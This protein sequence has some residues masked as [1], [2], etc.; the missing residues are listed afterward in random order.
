MSTQRDATPSHLK[1][2]GSLAM[3]DTTAK[4]VSERS[5]HA[6]AIVRMLPETEARL[7]AATLP[8]GD[9]FVAAQLAGIMAAKQTASLVP[10]AHPISISAVDVSLSWR[11]PG[12]LSIDAVAKTTASTGVEMEAMV[13][14]TIAA[15]TI[16]D[17]TKSLERGVRIESVRLLHKQG[18]RSGEWRASE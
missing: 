1:A 3:V 16:Y 13:A 17:M 7:R 6:Q 4:A 14:A 9:A 2:D 8:K 10:L 11:G 5:A 12:E 15:L 18:G